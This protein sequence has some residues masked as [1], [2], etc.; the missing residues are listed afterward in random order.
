M[1]IAVLTKPKI[2]FVG[3]FTFSIKTTIHIQT[4]TQYKSKYPHRSIYISPRSI[5][6]KTNKIKIPSVVQKLI[7][8]HISSICSIKKNIH[9]VI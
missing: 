1:I 5:D 9:C 3:R 8:K 6:R 2:P 4:Q 7:T